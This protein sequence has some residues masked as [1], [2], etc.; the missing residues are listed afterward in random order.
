MNFSAQQNFEHDQPAATGVLL[1]NL[2]TPDAPSKVAV[3]RYLKEFLQDPRVVEIPRWKWWIILNG[4][5]LNTR[6]EKSATAYQKVWTDAGSPLLTACYRQ[7]DKLEPVLREMFDDSIHVALAMRYGS[8]SIQSG[9]EA[10]REKG[11]G[12]IIVLPM[13]P[14]YSA[15]TTAST[16]DALA[17]VL[18]GWRRIPALHFID[19]YHDHPAYISALASSVK[20]HWRTH[21][22]AER[23]LIS[24]HG[25]PE[26][27][28]QAG[29]PYPCHCRKTA[30]LL[31]EQL[32][33]KD[34]RVFL[35]FQSRMGSEPWIQPYTDKTLQEW[36][37]AGVESVDVVCPGFAA[38]CLETLEEIA[39]QNRDLFLASGGRQYRYIPALNDAEAH[40]EALAQVLASHLGGEK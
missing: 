32:S 21:G 39:M 29:D 1:T 22:E 25:I 18:K 33:L 23:L 34:E 10:L 28:Y 36:G 17:D 2:G 35:C 14:Q 31:K 15:T 19:S 26:S 13:F 12:E 16:F 40:I 5:I 3:R 11:C 37:E 4:I 8:P 9:M 30:R 7:R 6:P 24:F 38:D 20:R 27:Y